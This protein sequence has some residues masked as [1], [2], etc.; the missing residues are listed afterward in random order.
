M[1]NCDTYERKIRVQFLS[2]LLNQ[3]YKGVSD[4]NITNIYQ[5]VNNMRVMLIG[6]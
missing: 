4:N 6:T 3:R 5:S 1:I 2:E